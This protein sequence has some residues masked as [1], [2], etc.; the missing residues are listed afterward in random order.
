[1]SGNTVVIVAVWGL[2]AATTP[3]AKVT[4]A[5]AAGTTSRIATQ[6]VS[7]VSPSKG[8]ATNGV[9]PPVTLLLR[10]SRT[11]SL[12]AARRLDALPMVA[13]PSALPDGRVAVAI[14]GWRWDH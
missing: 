10:F 8:L 9:R 7:P 6:S 5:V 2:S 4:L 1:M 12:P 3:A 11:F 13:N 14:E